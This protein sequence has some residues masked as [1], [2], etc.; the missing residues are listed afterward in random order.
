M[1]FYIMKPW[2]KP[3]KKTYQG[4]WVPKTWN[5]LNNFYGSSVWHDEYDN[6]YISGNVNG[7]FYLSH[8]VLDKNTDTWSSKAWT[9]S[10]GG[11]ESMSNFQAS[12]MWT[13]GSYTY[14]SYNVSS[15]YRHFRLNVSTS[16]WDNAGFV[17]NM[18]GYN[19][20]TDGDD[21]YYSSSKQQLIFNKTAG[22]WSTKTWSGLTNFD[23][24][25]VWTDGTKFYCPGTN[26]GVTSKYQYVLNNDGSSWSSKTW[27]IDL[28]TSAS[29]HWT[30][31]TDVYYSASGNQY[32][33]DKTTNTWVT[34]TWTGLTSFN[35]SGVWHDGDHIYYSSGTNQYELT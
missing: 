4:I 3:K 12:N 32:V 25:A 24:S 28:Y 1:A 19:V 2:Y 14:N 34:K 27:N 31:G 9:N 26:T 21:V 7:S 18:T 20:W 13:D 11:V 17:A 8:W 33:L 35:G 23:G 5:G 22:T 30:D 10:S 29:Y 6:T 16:N 15:G